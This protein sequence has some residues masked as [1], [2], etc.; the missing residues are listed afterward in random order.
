MQFETKYANSDGVRIAYQVVGDGPIDLIF[1]MGWVSNIEWAWQEPS[2]ARFLR[3]LSSFSRLIPFDKRGTGLS[4][5]IAT[6]PTFEERMD[7][8]RAVMDAVGSEQAALMG[9]SEGGALCTLFAATYPERTNALVTVGSFARRSW[10]R[11]YPYGLTLEEGRSFLDQIERG[12]GGPVGLTRRAPSVATDDRFRQWW[13]SYLR[14]SASPGAAVALTRMNLEIDIRHVL[15]AVRVP[16]LII[17]R[18][19]DLAIPVESGRFMAERI[20]GAR[21]FSGG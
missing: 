5:R 14:M 12:W 4:D 17:H 1:A 6:V 15:P 21:R 7:D 18:L 10:A 13:A 16:T 9:V 11:D 3:R 2:F 20:P 8:V 19:D